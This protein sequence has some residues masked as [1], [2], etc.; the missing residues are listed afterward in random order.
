MLFLFS[1]A[2]FPLSPLCGSALPC[3]A[4]SWL[5][6]DTFLRWAIPLLQ[7]TFHHC[8]CWDTWYFSSPQ[9]PTTMVLRAPQYSYI[10]APASPTSV[11]L[12]EK[13]WLAL[14][15]S[16]AYGA[17]P[18]TGHM[19]SWMNFCFINTPISKQ[20][21]RPTR[22][23]PFPGQTGALLL[24]FFSTSSS[25]LR[26]ALWRR[27]SLTDRKCLGFKKVASRE[28]VSIRGYL[29]TVMKKVYMTVE[30]FRSALNHTIPCDSK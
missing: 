17:S 14:S 21:D 23:I 24:G 7:E 16:C 19:K 27:S 25:P 20:E 3:A 1:D 10:Y 11:V 2:L 4:N 5:T 29:V 8:P 13:R 28:V 12:L 30:L 6:P 22:H 26:K 18:R 9:I 15:S